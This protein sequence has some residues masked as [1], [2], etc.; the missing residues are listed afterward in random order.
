MVLGLAPATQGQNSVSKQSSK[1]SVR[2]APDFALETIEED[3]VRLRD[4]R[5]D[6][7]VLNFWATWCSPCRYEIPGFIELQRQ[8]AD[9]SLQFVGVALQRGA[10]VDRVRRYAEHMEINYPVGA[11]DGTISEKYGSVQRLP[12]TFVIGPDGEIRKRFSGVVPIQVLR[13]GLERMLGNSS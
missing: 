4:H 2:R 11:D 13:A 3:T 5:G 1:D 10:G 9:Q 7:V 8:Y 12:T 6:V